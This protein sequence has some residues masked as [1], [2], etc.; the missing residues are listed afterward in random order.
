MYLL[1]ALLPHVHTTQINF[2][3]QFSAIILLLCVSR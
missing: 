2:I 1:Q 3:N